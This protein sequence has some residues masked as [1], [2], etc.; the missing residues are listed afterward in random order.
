MHETIF[1]ELGPID[2]IDSEEG[3]ESEEDSQD[4]HMETNDEEIAQNQEKFG[5]I[6]HIEKYIKEEVPEPIQAG[7]LGLCFTSV[8]FISTI[9]LMII[10]FTTFRINEAFE[11]RQGFSLYTI[12]F[13]FDDQGNSYVN[14]TNTREL[15][16]FILANV[17]ISN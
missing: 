10:F 8:Y 6:A 14:I 13:P 5:D 1:S 12:V 15:N 2:E 17:L 7:D 11:V 3:E 16:D 9:L 4:I